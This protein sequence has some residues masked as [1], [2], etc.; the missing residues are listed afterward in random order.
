MKLA[1][2][3]TLGV[4]CL[5]VIAKKE[6]AVIFEL[7]NRPNSHVRTIDEQQA[8]M[9][10]IAK[11]GLDD[12]YELGEVDSETVDLFNRIETSLER[13]HILL[14][15]DG[16][17]NPS[18]LLSLDFMKFHIERSEGSSGSL[19]SFF[20][21]LLETILLRQRKVQEALAMDDSFALKL[22]ESSPTDILESWSKNL[23]L[24][25]Y[26]NL[27]SSEQY[28][29]NELSTINFLGSLRSVGEKYGYES[30]SYTTAL[31]TMS[32]ALKDLAATHDV[33]V[34]AISPE[35]N[36]AN[37]KVLEKR[38]GDAL[39][40]PIF[41]GIERREIGSCFSSE[42]ACMST[43]RACTS[44]GKCVKLKSKCWSCLCSPSYDKKLKKT[45]KWTG[46]DC[47]KK[48]V[49]IETNLFLWSGLGL[50][51]FI[52]GGIKMLLSMGSEGLPDILDA[53]IS[54][55]KSQ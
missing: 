22:A 27:L 46:H 10:Y 34:L 36:V 14:V 29:G 44:H 16:I 48:D 5:T 6:D 21:E 55:K 51:V 31:K 39:N 54:N 23:I 28:Y 40:P 25:D 15:I 38:S 42:D 45:T 47:F 17:S 11:L 18:E 1:S 4:S 12:S 7:I 43:T 19:K 26:K 33:S 20:A 2:L 32:R 50:L 53:A 37:K 24:E 49:S 52:T 3:L 13:L 8:L 9:Y 35:V 41:T 30:D